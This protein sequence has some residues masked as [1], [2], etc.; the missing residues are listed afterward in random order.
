MDEFYV[1]NS[2]SVNI[3]AY[4]PVIRQVCE[5]N[6]ET[7]GIARQQLRKYATILVPLLVSFLR[8]P[9]GVLL[10]AVFTMSP[11]QAISL[12]RLSEC[13]VEQCSAKGC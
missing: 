11:P 4:R 1:E 6:N 13:S 3:T 7:T 8:A 12:N 10:E 9:M 5:T 2:I